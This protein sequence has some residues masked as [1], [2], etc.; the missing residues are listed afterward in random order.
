[1]ADDRIF[2]ASADRLGCD[3]YLAANRHARR[4]KI[5]STMGG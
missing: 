2:Y 4:S 1:M 5:H 3:V